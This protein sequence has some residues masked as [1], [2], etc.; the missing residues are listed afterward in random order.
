MNVNKHICTKD[1]GRERRDCCCCLM[2]PIIH[3][4]NQEIEDNTK[5]ALKPQQRAIY[6]VI[7]SGVIYSR[8]NIITNTKKH[9]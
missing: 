2:F 7:S 5:M 6:T 8:Y 9:N 1:A 4:Y 3:T